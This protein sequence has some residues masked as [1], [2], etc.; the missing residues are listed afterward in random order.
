MKLS[1]SMTL[2]GMFASLLSVPV[3]S[4]QAPLKKVW[5]IAP[6]KGPPIR[7]SPVVKA[8]PG[9]TFDLWATT[10]T[11]KT[12]GQLILKFR[13]LDATQE[14]S[15]TAPVLI[16]LYGS[17]VMTIKPYQIMKKIWKPG[18]TQVVIQYA[19]ATAKQ[20]NTIRGDTAFT[21]C[22]KGMKTCRKMSVSNIRFEFTP[23]L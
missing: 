12:S 8:K 9:P 20:V 16:D 6:P 17:G 23:S 22:K 2:I 21:V 19:G 1:H 14:L 15:K 7:V 18:T 10:T 13:P 3:W 11:L 4:A 5:K